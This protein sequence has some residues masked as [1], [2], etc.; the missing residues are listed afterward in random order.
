MIVKPISASYG[1]KTHR[2]EDVGEMQK[3]VTLI[4]IS[5]E[6][7]NSSDSSGINCGRI[8]HLAGNA[9]FAVYLPFEPE[10]AFKSLR[11]PC[12]L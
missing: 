3:H 11:K 9:N 5:W 6:A 10:L 7:E 12:S 1:N 2:A 8:P 4:A